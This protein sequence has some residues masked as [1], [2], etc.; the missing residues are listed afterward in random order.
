MLW[1]SVSVHSV[2]SHRVL[3]NVERSK[4]MLPLPNCH[5]HYQRLVFSFPSNS[6][7]FLR[8]YCSLD[9]CG[10]NLF[11]PPNVRI[12]IL[13]LKEWWSKG[14]LANVIYLVKLLII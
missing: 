5:S 12:K 11:P 13:L 8:I 4:V 1:G 10:C 2:F 7:N 6:S 9:S 3:S 14:E